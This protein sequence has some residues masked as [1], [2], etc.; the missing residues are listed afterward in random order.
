M[1]KYAFKYNLAIFEDHGKSGEGAHGAQ[2]RVPRFGHPESRRSAILINFDVKRESGGFERKRND[3]RGWEG[4]VFNF[5]SQT[6]K[7]A[8]ITTHSGKYPLG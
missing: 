4:G 7:F 5:V 3:D 2:Q 8:S 6:D 1:R